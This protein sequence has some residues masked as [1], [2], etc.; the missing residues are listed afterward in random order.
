VPR[1]KKRVTISHVA[2]EAGVSTQT[3]SRVINNRPNV[4]PETRQHVLDIVERLGYQPSAVARSLSRGRSYALG[5]VTAGLQYI[6]PSYT[7]NGIAEQAQ[8]MGYSLLLEELPRFETRDVGSVLDTL[9]ARR[10]DG[11]IW[12]VPQV[13]HNRDQL[14]ER[15]RDF[16]VP[17]VLLTMHQQAGFSVVATDNRAGARLATEHLI[18]QGYHHI[19]HIAGP[20]DWWEAQQRRAG[21]E[22]AL[23]RAGKPVRERHSTEGDWSSESGERAFRQLL[24]Q[25]PEV[26]A[27]FAGNDQMALGMLQVACRRGLSVP[28][29]LAVVGFDDIAESAYFWP[30]LTTVR[31][32]LSKMGR[33]AVDQ[34]IEAVEAAHDAENSYEPKNIL[35]RPELI[36]RESSVVRDREITRRA[37]PLPS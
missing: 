28:R 19:G 13:G 1:Q 17:I 18:S 12:A 22:N 23:H 11:I 16:P 6:G 4:A 37:N 9:L 24:D 27:V 10:V 35:L 5:I 31:Q 2:Q 3:V 34:I 20:M 21:W 14:L 36:V 7:L 26:D 8:E 25:Y 15:L 33:T 30:P 32:D 29:D